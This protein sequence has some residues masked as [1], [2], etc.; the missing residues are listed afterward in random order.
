M[1]L[2]VLRYNNNN[3]NNITLLR[4]LNYIDNLT[5]KYNQLQLLTT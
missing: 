1:I 3:N 2:Q 5:Y 4:K